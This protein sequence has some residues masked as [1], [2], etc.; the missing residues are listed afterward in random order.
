[1]YLLFDIGGTATKMAASSDG[2]KIEQKIIFPTPKK[3]TAA[4][5]IIQQKTQALAGDKKI[6]K[7]AG[8][9]AGVFNK[10]KTTLFC[11]PNLPDWNN[12]P[13][14]KNLQNI[15]KAPVIIENDA[16]VAG[17]GEATYGAGKNKRIVAYLTVS[18]GV[19][20]A[21]IVDQKIDKKTFGF[22]PGHQFINLP[23]DLESEISGRSLSKRLGYS[24]ELIKDKKIWRQIN[25]NLAYGLH[26]LTVFWS[27]DIIVLGGGISQDKNIDLN[28][29]KNQLKKT[30]LRFPQ[31]PEIKKTKFGDLAG[32]YGAKCLLKR[33]G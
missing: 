5:K 20:G 19:G 2:K 13:L 16:A 3:F 15:F 7:A 9:I 4:I 18:T 11:S 28:F 1:M 17:L 22:E 29:I 25:S 14:L 23:K 32:I 26:N 6:I 33:L 12:K 10:N 30:L 31:V 8:G 24:P 21:R 27:P